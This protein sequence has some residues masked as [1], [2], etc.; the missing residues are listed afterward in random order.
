M[1]AGRILLA[2]ALS[3][4]LAAQDFSRSKQS[5]I[6]FHPPGLSPVYRGHSTPIELQFRIANGL[7]I[8]S[9]QPKQEYLKKT[10]LNL[11]P[12]TDIVIE[13]VTYPD[14]Q[15][16]SFP[17]APDD[18]LSVYSGDIAIDVLVRPL[19]TVLP[20]KYAIHGVL[21]YQACDNAVCY[22]P[23]QLPLSFEV[24]VLK[25]PSEQKRRNPAQSPHAHA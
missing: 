8:N 3:C 24:Q 1:I 23:K 12:P 14:G 6:T 7:H 19:R 10:E 25:G 2:V 21:K 17:F 11:D 15:E 5:W 22:P 16:R 9:H 18:K 13:K 4:T 20:A